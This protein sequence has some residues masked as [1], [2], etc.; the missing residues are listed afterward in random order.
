M[1]RPGQGGHQID[2]LI[3][4]SWI[5]GIILLQVPAAM[6]A[7]SDPN[8]TSV[9]EI[10]DRWARWRLARRRLEWWR[11]GSLPTCRT[12]LWYRLWWGLR[13][14]GLRLGPALRPGFL[15][16]SS[17]SSSRC[18]GCSERPVVDDSD[19]TRRVVGSRDI[20]GYP[21]GL[22]DVGVQVSN[23]GALFGKLLLVLAGL[24]DRRVQ[25]LLF[26]GR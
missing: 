8:P 23:S 16:C 10:A 6:R 5:A 19:A 1:A 15:S 24:L 12:R 9:R 25:L 14:R 4:I 18:L 13:R 7:V 2:P 17:S 11:C 20:V 22:G 3:G 26:R 21:Y